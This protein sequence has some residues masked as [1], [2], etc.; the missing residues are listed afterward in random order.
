MC[1]HVGDSEGI[2]R[3]EAYSVENVSQVCIR[4]ALAKNYSA[5]KVAEKPEAL[6][7]KE[8][9]KEFKDEETKEKAEEKQ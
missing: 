1:V 3:T 6:W 5:E 2:G 8:G 4:N 9:S 7:V